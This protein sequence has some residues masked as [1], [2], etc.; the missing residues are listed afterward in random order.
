MA[1]LQSRLLWRYMRMMKSMIISRNKH[2]DIP[3]LRRGMS[4]AASRN[5]MPS[6]VKLKEVLIGKVS[7]ISFK[8][9]EFRRNVVLLYLHGGGYAVGSAKTHQSLVAQIAKTTKIRALSIN[10]RLAPEHPFPAALDDVMDTYVWL[11]NEG[12]EPGN[13]VFGG[14][15]AGGG[16]TLA[17]MLYAHQEELPSPAAGI[18]LSPWTDLT[19]TSNSVQTKDDIDPMLKASE[20]LTWGR[21]YA[22]SEELITYPLVSPLYAEEAALKKLPPVLIQ[23]GTSEILED[24]SKRFAAKAINAGADITLDVWE[25]MFHVWQFFWPIMPE[26]KKAIKGISSYINEHV[27]G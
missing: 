26:A 13:I 17:S 14:D 1:S 6:D 21:N 25:D 27:K 5:I 4:I 3:F 9:K 2:T 12:Y 10:Y 18:C 8:P 16:L 19:G 11:L 20:L 23:V 7:G 24:D 15:S 22:G